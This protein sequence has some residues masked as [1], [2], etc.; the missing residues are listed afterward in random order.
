MINLQNPAI[1]DSIAKNDRFVLFCFSLN[2]QMNFQTTATTQPQE[3]L[4]VQ[5]QTLQMFT[6]QQIIKSSH[7]NE[8]R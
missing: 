6:L 2:K 3:N 7:N 1:Q 5:F 4:C 8:A